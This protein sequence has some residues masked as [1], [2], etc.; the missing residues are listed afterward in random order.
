V[1][2][3]VPL[4]RRVA[5]LGPNGAGKTTL[6]RIAAG[7][8]DPD[9]GTV[10]RPPPNRIRWIAPADFGLYGRLTPRALLA[11]FAALDGMDAVPIDS[12][13]E[14]LGLSEFDRPIR[15]LSAG[16]RARLVLARG[17][18]APGDLWLLDEPTRSLDPEGRR[19]AREVLRT[20]ITGAPAVLVT[21]DLEEVRAL[22]THWRPLVAGRLGF[23]RAVGENLAVEVAAAMGR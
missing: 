15:T 5:I 16:A 3:E 6:L 1:T 19:M 4:G 11:W 14:R 23:E 21:H 22:A 18:L 13:L 8:L 20:A 12:L 9:R 7:L 2:L 17:L 10:R